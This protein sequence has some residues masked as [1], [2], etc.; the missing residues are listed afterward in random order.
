M[1][2]G[3]MHNEFTCLEQGTVLSALIKALVSPNFE[4]DEGAAQL[5]TASSPRVSASLSRLGM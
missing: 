1:F 3:V 5:A 4:E 2:I